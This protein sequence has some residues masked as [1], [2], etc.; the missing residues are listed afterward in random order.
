LKNNKSTNKGF[1]FLEV[2]TAI[3]IMSVAL[4]PILS[5]VPVSLRM[6]KKA[7]NKMFAIFLAQGRL[8]EL[9]IAVLN[10]F[11]S[12][13]DASNI[14]FPAP[15]QNFRYTITDSAD[16]G[17]KTLSVTVWSMDEPNDKVILY[18]NIALR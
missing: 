10:N 11:S 5:W 9:R 17:L 14:V 12:D 13:Y 4:V 3:L 16:A 8:E 15:Y 7:E 1:T 6:K 2:L 18:T